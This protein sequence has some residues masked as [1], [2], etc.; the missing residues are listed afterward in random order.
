MDSR[1]VT[2]SL[3]AVVLLIAGCSSSKGSSN[4]KQPPATLPPTSPASSSSTT[5]TQ[6]AQPAL[7]G[8]WQRR[9]SCSE[10]VSILTRAGLQKQVPAAVAGDE[11]VPGV[12]QV[13]QLKDPAHPCAGAN[14]R[15]HSHFFTADGNFGSRDDERQQVDDGHYTLQGSDTLIMDGISVPKVTFHYKITG[16]DTLSLTPVVPPC[17][18]A[19][20]DAQW[21]VSVAYQGYT[22]H[23]IG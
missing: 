13:S 23:R 3:C 19:C 21:S 6:P 11:W 20:E 7:V 8:E 14:S 9:Q 15:L 17:P 16:N 22:W 5:A 4:T 2:S 1:R 10:L 12:S 18:P